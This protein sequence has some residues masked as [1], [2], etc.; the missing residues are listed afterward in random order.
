MLH[1]KASKEYST[2]TT[3]GRIPHLEA[4]VGGHD[5]CM[6]VRIRIKN[7]LVEPLKD[8]F[9]Y[10]YALPAGKSINLNGDIA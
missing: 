6:S 2:K 10:I 8:A 5:L 9:G 1:C 4:R 7:G 3:E